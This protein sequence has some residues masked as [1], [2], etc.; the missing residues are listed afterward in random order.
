MTQIRLLGVRGSTPATGVAFARHG[1]DTSCVALLDDDGVP[2]LLLDLGTG[3][4]NLGA[5]TGGAAFLGTAWLTHLHWDHTHGI[6]FARTLDHD[7]AQLRVHL[8]EQGVDPRELVA[9]TLGPPHFPI[10]PDQ[11]RGDWSFESI[12]EGWHEVPFGDATARVLAREIPHKG[13]RTFGYRVEAPG[14]R[15]AYMP[16][17]HPGALGAGEDG[18]GPLHEAALTLADGVDVLLHDA[19]Y[20]GEE[21][22]E[23]ASFGHSAVEYAVAL[24]V[25]AGVGQLVLFHHDP[26]RTDVE[27]D[28][29]AAAWADHP[30]DVVVARQHSHSDSREG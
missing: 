15:V 1:G 2:R 29:V 20:L 26:M 4:R 23:R 17:H 6:P 5:L 11:L 8:P 7:E 12:D 10:T 14:L 21:Y 19:Q 16:D 30:L 22:A 27:L 28:A 13:G 25:A 18:Y 3:A 9:R 24:G